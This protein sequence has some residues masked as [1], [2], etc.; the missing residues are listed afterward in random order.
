MIM[1]ESE[2]IFMFVETWL[3]GNLN[4]HIVAQ[5]GKAVL[6]M[7]SLMASMKEG[8]KRAYFAKGSYE[9]KGGNE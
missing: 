9:L 8:Y 5:D 4:K 2:K 7:E 1:E 3:R 6:D